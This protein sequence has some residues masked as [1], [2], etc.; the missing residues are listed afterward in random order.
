MTLI[1]ARDWFRNASG[2]AP[3]VAASA[4]L[5]ARVTDA[6]QEARARGLLDSL[7]WMATSG[8]TQGVAPG[9]FPVARWVGHSRASLRASA[10][11]VVSALEVTRSD[12]WARILPL[13]HM[14][15]LSLGFRAEVAGFEVVEWEQGWD[16][17]AVHAWLESQQATRVSAVPTQLHDWVS[18]GLRAP[19]S[20]RTVLVGADRL[21]PGLQQK[22]RALGWPVVASY[23]MTETA[24]MIACERP[25]HEGLW[26]VPEIQARV[27]EEDFLG[28][29]AEC[30]FVA[31]LEWNAG[32][33]AYV[34]VDRPPGVW[35]AADRVRLSPGSGDGRVR[36]EVLGRGDDTVKIQGEAVD[37]AALDAKLAL[38]REQHPYLGAH[39]V[40]AVFFA[41]P[42]ERRGA[43]LH[44]AVVGIP[45]SDAEVLLSLWNLGA[46]PCERAEQI[47]VR[48]QLPRTELGKLR[49]KLLAE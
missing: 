18:L 39:G 26:L 32:R 28:L 47:H 45:A 40:E 1:Q 11:S 37:L 5:E 36:I 19:A 2:E 43:Q 13:H 3:F 10:R 9:A 44:V 20:L 42:D 24:S 8:T 29:S 34:K 35:R 30:L 16:P 38:L 17:A 31:Q 7:L 25:G 48:Q 14:G 22:A 15:G 6:L 49:R 33:E 12:R 21:E 4:H 41:L 27:D 23:G 46:A